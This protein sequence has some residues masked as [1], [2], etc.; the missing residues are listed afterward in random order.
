MNEQCDT[1][2]EQAL[3]EIGAGDSTAALASA[4]AAAKDGSLLGSALAQ[5]L[6]SSQ[7]GSVYAT[8][9]GFEAFIDGGGNIPLYRSVSAALAELYEEHQATSLLDI[10]SGNG[11]ALVPALEASAH[12]PARVQLVEPSEALLEEALSQLATRVP[13][14]EVRSVPTNVQKFVDQLPLDA[15]WTVAQSTFALHTLPPEERTAALAR[16]RPHVG[17]L[18]IVEFDVPDH[19]VGGPE[20][21]A[22]LAETYERGLAE[23]DGDRDLV[24]Q[25]FLMPVLVGQLRPGAERVTW[26]QSADRW[27]SQLREAGYERISVRPVSDYWSSPAFLLRAS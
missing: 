7:D 20:H 4:E 1:K 12:S 26:E 17:V 16:L 15:N 14:A 8:P 24:A 6:R 21:L 23:Y 2:I 19:T 25:G 5:Y 13:A 10:G 22:F 9:A 11:R 3:V 18:A 27:E